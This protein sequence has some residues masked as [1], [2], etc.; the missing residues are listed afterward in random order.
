MRYFGSVA[1]LLVIVSTCGISA[2]GAEAEELLAVAGRHALAENVSTHYAIVLADGARRGTETYLRQIV[3]SYC[4]S[5]VELY[6]QTLHGEE[7]IPWRSVYR[8]VA[9]LDGRP[10][11]FSIE[12]GRPLLES[13]T[14]G[15][16]VGE[17]LEIE[18]TR[19]GH[20]YRKTVAWPKGAVIVEGCRLALSK[21]FIEPGHAVQ[22]QYF[23]VFDLDFENCSFAPAAD[24]G[25]DQPQG[26]AV[27]LF[28]LQSVDHEGRKRDYGQW[29]D[30][31]GWRVRS[32]FMAGSKAITINRCSEE[33]AG[34][35]ET[36]TQ[37]E[38]HALA[39]PQ[40]IPAMAGRVTMQI[41]T[42]P[43]LRPDDFPDVPQQHISAN[44]DGTL[45][46]SYRITH[47]NIS[48]RVAIPQSYDDPELGR[49]L[50]P[51]R[52]VQ[53]DD[54]RIIEAAGEA[55]AG[56]IQALRVAFAIAL[57]VRQHVEYDARY[58]LGSASDVI[59]NGKGVCGQIAYLTAAMCRAV[60]IP[61][62]IAIGYAYFP[63][64]DTFVAHA[65]AQA[66]VG[67]EW[68]D[69]EVSAGRIISSVWDGDGHTPSWPWNSM[70]I[71]GVK[72]DYTISG[73]YGFSYHVVLAASAALAAMLAV[74]VSVVRAC[75]RKSA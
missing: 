49:F 45:K 10:V 8:E 9:T 51:T 46:I 18:E 28:N 69:L 44:T 63:D 35:W 1:V 27:R 74:G 55:V 11:C 67:G 50:L 19:S 7:T 52:M 24:G 25:A 2:L 34:A 73:P 75:R 12:M 37:F 32:E 64:S 33:E 66:Y 31:D 22:L 42:E 60:N 21:A 16:I 40:P 72:V 4:V 54:P 43:P 6:Q 3:G 71:Q 61:A 58:T 70:T 48:D 47:F 59:A 36:T 29:I 39:S 14:V 56:E 38:F 5:S 57:W 13:K 20:I 15:R 23:N 53:S 68:V 41:S 62:R 17:T 30:K 65:W 26:E